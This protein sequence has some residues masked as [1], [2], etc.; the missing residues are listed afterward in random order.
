[1]NT[2]TCWKCNHHNAEDAKTC[3]YCED[4]T[5]LRIGPYLVKTELGK[6]QFGTVF[7]AVN[8][9]LGDD[10]LVAIKLMREPFPNT[11]EIKK[12]LN[13]LWVLPRDN[14]NLVHVHEDSSVECIVMDYIEGDNLH[15]RI[16]A[17]R[18]LVIENYEKILKGICTGLV[19]LH[20]AGIIHRDLK[21][22]NIQVTNDWVPK[23]V[24]MGLAKLVS[25]SGWACSKVGSKEVAA[26]EILALRE[27]EKY[28]KTVDLWALGVIAYFI[29]TGHYPFGTELHD[30]VDRR[31]SGE[32][33]R[34]IAAINYDRPE[35]HNKDIP[36][37]VVELIEGLLTEREK[38][39]ASA[40]TV[41]NL[42]AAAPYTPGKASTT[43][44]LSDYQ[45]QLVAIYG[46]KN[47][48]RHP[49]QLLGRVTS[50]VGFLERAVTKM[51]GG[52]QAET[53]RKYLPRT[54][55]WLVGLVDTAGWNVGDV[56]YYKYPDVCPYCNEKPCN[57]H[58]PKPN[59]AINTSLLKKVLRERKPAPTDWTFS[60]V[61]TMFQEIYG[62]ANT[63]RTLPEIVLHIYSE[64]SEL[65]DAVRKATLSRGRARTAIMYLEL[66]DVFAW[67]F[68]LHNKVHTGMSGFEEEFWTK[69][70]TC[71]WCG[72]T[73]CKCPEVLE[74]IETINWRLSRATLEALD[75]AGPPEEGQ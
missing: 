71:P 43:Y 15:K 19:G 60:Q 55:A 33:E 26:P 75:V 61:A 67:F 4:Y 3:A 28:D 16:R 62:V 27:G 30:D 29:W 11:V 63:D 9:A 39:F 18:Q 52:Q 14:P 73:Q 1:M 74:N 36:R 54:F 46:K 57:M 72:E 8:P 42:I 2:L 47:A 65:E 25:H 56:I 21:P 58:H 5:K 70:K 53:F 49:V 41:L 10:A 50:N 35:K 13:L 45:S 24:D 32:I 48:G 31:D 66:A 12:E 51:S 59:E 23:I 68:A 38:R 64:I 6:G 37:S 44:L 34:A 40:E 20:N 22:A 17:N 69:F 7:L